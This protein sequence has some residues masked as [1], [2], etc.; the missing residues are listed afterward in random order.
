MC[1]MVVNLENSRESTKQQN[2]KESSK[3]LELRREFSK[4]T[5]YRANVQKS[6]VY[7]HTSSI[8][9]KM[10]FLNVNYSSTKNIKS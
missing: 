8:K 3:N 2:C 7:L 9:L 5:G 10:K 6:T 1:D 4:V